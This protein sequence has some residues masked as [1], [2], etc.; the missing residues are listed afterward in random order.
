MSPLTT[1]ILFRHLSSSKPFLIPFCRKR[2]GNAKVRQEI[3][4]PWMCLKL[5]AFVAE[6][7]ANT[8]TVSFNK[9]WNRSLWLFSCLTLILSLGE[10]LRNRFSPPARSLLMENYVVPIDMFK[11]S[12]WEYSECLNQP[13]EVS[14]FLRSSGTKSTKTSRVE[15]PW[16]T[17]SIWPYS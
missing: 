10:S 15:T 9:R 2:A 12:I 3:S 6:G 5:I 8:R 17:P 1:K 4:Q 11:S 7:L 13:K 16:L 14:S